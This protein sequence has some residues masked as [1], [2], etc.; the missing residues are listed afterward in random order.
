MTA[1]WMEYLGKPWQAAPA[2]PDSYNCGELVRE[3]YRKHLSIEMAPIPADALD[4]R[5]CVAAMAGGRYGLS[6]LPPENDPREFDVVFLARA[7]YDDHCGLAV[8]TGEGLMI[9]H[10]QRGAGVLLDSPFDLAVRGYRRLSWYRH[11]EI[12]GAHA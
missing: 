4:L 7:K 10:C 2:P 5:Q 3:I 12:G 6:P 11:S 8:N 9:L 1:W